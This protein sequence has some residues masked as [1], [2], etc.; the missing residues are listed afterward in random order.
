MNG[1]DELT[2]K[3]IAQLKKEGIANPMV[4]PMTPDVVPGTHTHDQATLHV[5]LKGELHILDSEGTTTIY[6]EGDRVEFP[7]GTT[8]TATVG[9]E[10]C[11]MIVGIKI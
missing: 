5:I 1:F 10:G 9:A 6:R 7:A 2:T 11:T 8:H 3:L 4:V